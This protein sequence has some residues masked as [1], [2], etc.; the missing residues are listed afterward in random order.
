MTESVCVCESVG[1]RDRWKQRDRQ[2]KPLG[3][4]H[5]GQS[6]N[7]KE[8]ARTKKLAGKRHISLMLHL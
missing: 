8:A 3:Q 2:M 6:R 7:R 5:L 1:V 4:Q